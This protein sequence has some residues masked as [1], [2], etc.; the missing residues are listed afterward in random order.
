M[1]S[2]D[3]DLIRDRIAADGTLEI[4]LEQVRPG[5]KVAVQAGLFEGIRGVFERKI[6]DNEKVLLL[7]DAVHHHAHMLIEQCYVHEVAP[8]V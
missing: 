7:L 8:V 2:K 5:Q 3:I 6:N 1:D 4:N